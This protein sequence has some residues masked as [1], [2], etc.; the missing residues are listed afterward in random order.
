MTIVM[1][2]LMIL[3]TPTTLDHLMMILVMI[4]VM[5]ILQGRGR[6]HQ[7]PVVKKQLQVRPK[8]L[9]ITIIDEYIAGGPLEKFFLDIMI[10]KL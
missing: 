8:E 6:E 9:L 10:I 7:R 3:M 4:M 5:M 1:V 2:T